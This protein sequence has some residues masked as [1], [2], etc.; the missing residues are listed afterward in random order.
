MNQ[1]RGGV[2]FFGAYDPSYPRNAILRAGLARSGVPVAEC[3]V[4]ERLKVHARY[5]ALIARFLGARGRGRVIL[6][7][8]FRHKDVP[9][10]WALA[11]CTGKR[12]VFDP[13]VS[14]YETR[15]LD[16][17]DAALGSAQARHNW[18]IDAISMRLPDLLLADTAAHAE[19][20][21]REFSVP[22]GKISVVPV[23]F[24]DGLFREAAPPPRRPEI[25]VL[26]YGSF[27]PLHGADTI[28]EAAHLL[29][30]APVRFL[31][32]GAGQTHDAFE[33]RARDLPPGKAELRPPVPA[34]EL[35]GIIASADVVLGIFG[36]GPKA[37]M[38]VP[39]KVFQS[40]AVGRPV[41]TGDTPAIREIF[42]DGAHL[43]TVPPGDAASLAGAIARLAGDAA[44]RESLGRAGGTYA[45]STFG[46]ARIGERCA[47]SLREA[48]LL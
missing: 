30:D 7:P 32:V 39:N 1:P 37:G 19:F 38:V 13:L 2:L 8:D 9:L 17:A 42:R 34:G 23:G 40:L 20:Y 5:P 35:P 43:L 18:N 4:D 31:F 6:V 24:D 12:L 11:R 28:V 45:R 25:T 46:T 26:F 16:R 27:L 14:R 47:A 29:R 44:L 15:V 3:R 48:G 36:A 33:R 10:A 41:I 21:S 22:R